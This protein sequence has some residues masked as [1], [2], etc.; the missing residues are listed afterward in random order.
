MYAMP[1]S[2][3]TMMISERRTS[4]TMSNTGDERLLE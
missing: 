2:K 4:T 3:A 1:V